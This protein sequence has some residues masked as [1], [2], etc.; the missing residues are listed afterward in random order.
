MNNKFICTLVSCSLRAAIWV[1]GRVCQ[2]DH[3]AGNQTLSRWRDTRMFHIEDRTLH[4]P[5]FR[6]IHHSRWFLC[7][8]FL[9]SGY[10]S[11]IEPHVHVAEDKAPQQRPWLKHPYIHTSERERLRRLWRDEAYNLVELTMYVIYI[12]TLSWEKNIGVNWWSNI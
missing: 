10:A 11:S 12:G 7:L 6:C 9:A 4:T 8:V 2:D 3:C 5:T 1:W